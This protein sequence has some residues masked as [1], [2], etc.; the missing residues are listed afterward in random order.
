MNEF[1]KELL[2]FTLCFLIGLGLFL[3]KSDDDTPLTFGNWTIN[4]DACASCGGCATE[5]VR[6]E[7]AVKAVM[8]EEN[9]ALRVDCPAF[10]KRG[11][12]LIEGPENERCPTGAISREQLTDSTY[13]YLVDEDKCIGCGKCTRVCLKKCDGA[14]KLILNTDECHDC[15]ECD[16]AK[17]CPTKAVQRQSR[18]KQK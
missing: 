13:R 16:I 10:F 3:I 4:N 8:T 18:E 9:C 1:K 17:S 11:A 12:A 7:S 5:C 14:L 6:P 15:N 2:I